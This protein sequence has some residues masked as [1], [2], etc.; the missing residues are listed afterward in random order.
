MVS[1]LAGPG[2]RNITGQALIVDGGM[3]LHCLSEALKGNHCRVADMFV[4][5]YCLLIDRKSLLTFRALG[6]EALSRCSTSRT[7]RI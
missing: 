1:F 3:F 7:I 2:S 5:R 6:L 4:N